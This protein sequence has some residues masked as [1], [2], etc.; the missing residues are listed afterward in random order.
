MVPL[1]VFVEM[2]FV[3]E[4][5]AAIGLGTRQQC[6]LSVVVV[7]IMHP[8]FMRHQIPVGFPAEMAHLVVLLFFVEFE[9]MRKRLISLYMNVLLANVAKNGFRVSKAQMQIQG[10]R[11]RINFF[12]E[13]TNGGQSF[14]I[15]ETRRN[16]VGFS[17]VKI[18]EARN[19]VEVEAAFDRTNVAVIRA[20]H[21]RGCERG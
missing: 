4:S 15:A 14:G 2:N 13:K 17:H 6:P 3:S 10:F 1:S 20:F 11:V 21:S 16:C 19:A 8:Q 7:I 12:A 18:P 5:R 9:V